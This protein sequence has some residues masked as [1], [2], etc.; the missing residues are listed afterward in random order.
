MAGFRSR[1]IIPFFM[2]RFD[3][4]TNV[5]GDGQGFVDR[6]RA[7]FEPIRERLPFDGSSTRKREPFASSR[8]LAAMFGWLS[9][10]RTSASRWNR[11]TR[12]GSRE[13]SSGRIL[14]ATSRFS[15]VCARYTSPFPRGTDSLREDE[16]ILDRLAKQGRLIRAKGDLLEI[17]LPGGG[18]STRATQAL[19]E[20]CTDRFAL[21]VWSP[22]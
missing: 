21:I 22:Y 10:A 3:G 2:R 4:F 11:L 15:F 19:D 7:G 17:G 5:L 16:S 13:N 6:Q 8:L 9:E 18:P 14:I 12:T 20:L 1:W